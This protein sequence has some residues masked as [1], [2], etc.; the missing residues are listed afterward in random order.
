MFSNHLSF[1]FRIHANSIKKKMNTL[2]SLEV[3]SAFF[4]GDVFKYMDFK[5]FHGKLLKPVQKGEDK[6]ALAGRE[7]VKAKRLIGALRYLWRS[8]KN[9]LD[10][11]VSD[12]KSLLQRSPARPL[13]VRDPEVFR[14]NLLKLYTRFWSSTVRANQV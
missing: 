11:R 3:P 6:L 2:A 10:P 1:V 7:G 5:L 4:L 8:S 13:R 14:L 9:S 12:L